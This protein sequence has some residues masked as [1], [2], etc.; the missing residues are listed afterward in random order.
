M[1]TSYSALETYNQCPQKFKF[2]VLDKIKAP[3]MAE[4]V[5][6]TVVHSALKFMFSKNPLFPTLEEVVAH[7]TETWRTS[8]PK[9]YPALSPEH[10]QT[11]EEHGVL[12]LKKFFKANPPWN[13]SVVDTE[14]RFEILLPDP[15]TAQTHMIVG[16]IDRIDKI[17][18]GEYE[19]IDYKTNRKIH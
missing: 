8:A 3:K 12:L 7:F 13:F 2:Q 16:I 9:I 4:T 14:S 11:Y 17:G 19:I 10:Q 1:R 5:F 18:D 6:G 15:E